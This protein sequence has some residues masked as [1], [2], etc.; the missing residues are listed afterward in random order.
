V[1]LVRC[2]QTTAV[3]G[4]WLLI[5][6]AAIE[7]AEFETVILKDGQTVTGEIVA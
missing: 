4:F 2:L 1:S 5:T 3:I 7:A 6:A